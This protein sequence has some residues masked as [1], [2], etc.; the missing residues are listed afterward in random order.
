MHSIIKDF[1]TKEE[2]AL[3]KNHKEGLLRS[4]LLGLGLAMCVVLLLIATTYTARVHLSGMAILTLTTIVA[5]VAVGPT[6]WTSLNTSAEVLVQLSMWKN[7]EK[8]VK[9]SPE[10]WIAK[11]GQM[12]EVALANLKLVFIRI[13]TRHQTGAY[14]YET[15]PLTTPGLE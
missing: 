11:S 10:Y 4:I 8:E 12:R 6:I 13:K 15:S 7:I 2:L 5:M 9:A 1:L 14:F 3:L